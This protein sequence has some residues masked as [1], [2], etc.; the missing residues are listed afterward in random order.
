MSLNWH[1]CKLTWAISSE[2]MRPAAAVVGDCVPSSIQSSEICSSPSP[3]CTSVM[4]WAYPKVGELPG[5]HSL[6]MW[7]FL[8]ARLR[9]RRHIMAGTACDWA[10]S[11]VNFIAITGATLSK[12]GS[13]VAARYLPHRCG[14]RRTKYGSSSETCGCVSVA[15]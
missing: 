13:L 2:S 6:H 10:V 8:T 1:G 5:A 12:T 11:R 7:C 4:R 3:T 14:S 15:G 9:S